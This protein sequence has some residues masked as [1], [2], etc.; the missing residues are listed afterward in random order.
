MGVSGVG[1]WAEESAGMGGWLK[2]RQ[3]VGVKGGRH[4]VAEFVDVRDE[5]ETRSL[6]LNVLPSVLAAVRQSAR[7]IKSALIIV[8]A[9]KTI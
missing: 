1:L 7:G 2:E 8:P 6:H 9:L 4:D 3:G 5:E